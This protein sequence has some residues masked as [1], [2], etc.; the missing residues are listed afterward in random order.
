MI[1]GVRAS[2]MRMLSTS[3]TIAKLWVAERPAVL[4]DALAVLDL[5][6]MLAAN[7]AP[8]TWVKRPAAC[9]RKTIASRVPVSAIWRMLI[10]N[11]RLAAYGDPC[12][13]H[14]STAAVALP[15][16]PDG[17]RARGHAKTPESSTLGVPTSGR[18]FAACVGQADALSLSA[19]SRPSTTSPSCTRPRSISR[20]AYCQGLN[21][22]GCSAV[23]CGLGSSTRAGAVE[24][25]AVSRCC[26]A[27]PRPRRPAPRW[28]PA[29]GRKLKPQVGAAAAGQLVGL[30]PR[31]PHEPRW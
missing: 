21:G 9:A 19:V 30:L 26:R 15:S 7:W 25:C 23:G 4:A 10:R 6:L 17:A 13:A 1:S 5:L 24:P 27:R 12:G 11:S 29:F 22:N 14:F 28:R 8:P 2:S 20:R 3:S 16:A 18:R 31:A